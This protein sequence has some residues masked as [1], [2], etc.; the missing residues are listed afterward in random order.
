MVHINL[1]VVVSVSFSVSVFKSVSISD[2]ILFNSFQTDDKDSTMSSSSTC[3][4]E[5]NLLCN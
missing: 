5:A 1:V 4:M 2:N 3:N